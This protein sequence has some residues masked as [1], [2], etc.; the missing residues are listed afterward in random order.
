MARRG[1][2][3]AAGANLL[4]SNYL[5]DLDVSIPMGTRRGRPQDVR[6]GEAEMPRA[7]FSLVKRYLPKS[8]TAEHRSLEARAIRLLDEHAS[9]VSFPMGKARLLM[10]LSV[11]PVV[12]GLHAIRAEFDEAA[13]VKVSGRN[14]AAMRTKALAAHPKFREAL[15]D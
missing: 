5:I 10:P 8:W 1:T 2:N 11:E 6:L 7:I 9:P 15:E 13:D 14:Y 12:E 3:N 4:E